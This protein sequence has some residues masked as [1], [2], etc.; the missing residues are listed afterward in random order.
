MQADFQWKYGQQVVTAA[1]ARQ[2]TTPLAS[3]V[4]QVTNQPS[5]A[6][7]A[8]LDP[9][10]AA[11][12][13]VNVVL[14]D[15]ANRTDLTGA[16]TVAGNGQITLQEYEATL[17]PSYIADLQWERDEQQEALR[18]RDEVLRQ[19]DEALRQEQEARQKEKETS[20]QLRAELAR[21]Q[22]VSHGSAQTTGVSEPPLQNSTAIGG[23]SVRPG[24]TQYASHTVYVPPATL[25]E[26]KQAAATEGLSQTRS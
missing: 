12:Q 26:A 24:L 7:G 23:G 6:T 3:S 2:Q 5:G 17:D 14:S 20:E 21:V 4:S 25:K 19:R 1:G 13:P 9:S 10:A 18:Q 11:F 8:I 16:A 22:Q 15:G